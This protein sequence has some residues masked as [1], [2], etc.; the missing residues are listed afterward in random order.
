MVFRGS[1]GKD[2]RHDGGAVSVRGLESVGGGVAGRPVEEEAGGGGGE[3]RPASWTH[4]LRPPSAGCPS[5]GCHGAADSSIDDW[6]TS[7]PEEF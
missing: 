2:S 7:P 1:S 4:R 3:E 5:A 6:S